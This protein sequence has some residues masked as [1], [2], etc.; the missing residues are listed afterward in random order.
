LSPYA[1]LKASAVNN[2]EY[3]FLPGSTNV[4]LDNNFVSNSHMDFI[5]P[6]EEF[7]LFLGIDESM[8]VEYK[9]LQREKKEAGMFS[10]TIQYIYNYQIQITNTKKT[11]EEI[12]VWDQLPI[13]NNERIQVKLISPL[14]KEESENLKMNEYKY[15][16]WF[17]SVQPGNKII[18]PFK[19][20]VEYPS[21]M[22]VAG[23]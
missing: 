2:T 18:I 1:Y 16:E 17:Y 11:D 8:K 23:L 5:S 14:Y 22:M 4:F 12:T 13:S 21:E 20:S 7:K 19:F 9:F 6:G 10:K 15:L 3:P